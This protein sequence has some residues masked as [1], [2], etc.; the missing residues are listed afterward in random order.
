ME[1]ECQQNDSLVDGYFKAYQPKVVAMN[2]GGASLNPA[3]W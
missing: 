2:G 3:R 1:R